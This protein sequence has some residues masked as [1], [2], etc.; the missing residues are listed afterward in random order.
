MESNNFERAL[1]LLSKFEWIHD[2]QVID[3]FHRKI[4]QEKFPSEVCLDFKLYFKKFFKLVIF[5]N[6]KV[7]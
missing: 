1:N 7:A 5:L 2:F 3:I 6:K 4:F